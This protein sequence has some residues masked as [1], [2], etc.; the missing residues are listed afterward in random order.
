MKVPVNKENGL[1]F[2]GPDMGV[3]K[4]TATLPPK[5]TP[6]KPSIKKATEKTKSNKITNYMN[7]QTEG[8]TETITENDKMID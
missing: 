4:N 5:T 8:K 1:V 3:T 2:G 7:K 6:S